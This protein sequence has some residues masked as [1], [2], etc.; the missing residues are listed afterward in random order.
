MARGRAALRLAALTVA[1]LLLAA[2]A[3]ATT[4]NVTNDTNLGT[5]MSSAVAGDVVNIAAGSYTGSFVPA[6]SGSAGSYIRIVGSQAN[7]SS[8]STTDGLDWATG[9][10]SYISWTGI[11]VSDDVVFTRADH[12]S[13][14]YA[15][16]DSG[17]FISYGQNSDPASDGISTDNYIGNSTFRQNIGANSFVV[18]LR[19]TENTTFYRCRFFTTI[20]NAASDARGRY[21]YRSRGNTFRECGTFIECWG[22]E[23]GEQYAQGIRDTSANN[24]FDTD[25]LWVGLTS[26]RSRRVLL[27]QSGSNPGTATPN[28]WVNCD[29]RSWHETATDNAFEFQDGTGGGVFNSVFACRIGRPLTF[30]GSA[31]ATGIVLRH[32]TAYTSD[33][34]AFRYDVGT[35]P[36]GTSRVNACAFLGRGTTSCANGSTLFHLA[37]LGAFAAADSNA[38]ATPDTT[39]VFEKTTGGTVCYAQRAWV[40]ATGNEPRSAFRLMAGGIVADTAWATLDLRPASAS[41]FLKSASAPDGYYGAFDFT[42]SGGGATECT[43]P[44]DVYFRKEDS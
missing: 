13:L 35:N 26:Q 15:R 41:S 1:A 34:Q 18:L 16:A 29:Y 4:Y 28:W 24:T 33:K 39:N 30:P 5:A 23:S 32:V 42:E 20:T 25:T 31:A 3:L 12:C 8:V 11:K 43:C 22:A 37:A 7:P 38:F 44:P 14:T 10:R 6:N 19:R 40:T 21:L 9:T 27:S 2:P 17:G 36:T